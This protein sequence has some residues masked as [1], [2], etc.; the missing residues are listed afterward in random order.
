MTNNNIKNEDQEYRCG[1]VALLGRPNVGKSSIINTLLK[2][3][4]AAVSSKPQTTRNAIRCILTTEKEQIIFVDTPGIHKPKHVLG[5]FMVKEASK[6]LSQV[7]L[8]CLVVE[9]GDRT[10]GEKEELILEFLSNCSVPVVLA[11][12]KI[13]KFSDQEVFWK[14]VEMYETRITPASVVPLSAKKGTNMDVFIETLSGML[15]M[16]PP[17]YPADMLMDTTERFLAAEVIREKILNFTDQEVPHGTAVVVEEFK[18]PEE[19]P[20]LKTCEI[21]ATII[22]DREGQKAIIIGRSGAKLKTIGMAARKELEEKFG[23]PIYLQLWVKVKP[24]WRKSQEELRRLGYS[25]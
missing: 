2:E 12:N 17:I 22:V 23:Y 18:S 7:D 3:K 9:A 20:E 1:F 14:T 8:V 10:I 19:Y 4:V 21:R 15:P 24:G 13:D 25:F 5:D 16:Q 6:T 11:V